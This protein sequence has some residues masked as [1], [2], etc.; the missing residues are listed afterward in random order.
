MAFGVRTLLVNNC[1]IDMNNCLILNEYHMKK[2][3]LI[4]KIR[5]INRRSKGSFFTV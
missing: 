3:W 2:K 5:K 1:I 4:R